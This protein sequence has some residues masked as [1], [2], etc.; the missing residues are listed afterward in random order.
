MIAPNAAG[1]LGAA[2]HDVWQRSPPATCKSERWGMYALTR[3]YAR[4]MFRIMRVILL[5]L[6]RILRFSFRYVAKCGLKR[7]DALLGGRPAP[8]HRHP[9]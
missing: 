3:P 9:R 8:T 5:F 4:M 1:T 2:S 7:W 6:R